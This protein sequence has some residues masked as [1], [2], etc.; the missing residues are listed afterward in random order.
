M[1]EPVVTLPPAAPRKGAP[2]PAPQAPPPGPTQRL[3]DAKTGEAVDLDP[4]AARAALASGAAGFAPQQEVVLTGPGG[5]RKVSGDEARRE[6]LY[7]R[8][9]GLGSEGEWA[10]AE[11]ERREA[12]EYGGVKGAVEAA[13]AG[14]LRGLTF[15]ASDWAARQL[16]AGDTFAKL[17]K[18][19]EGASIAGELAGAALPVVLSGGA[20]APEEAALIAARGG[21]TAAREGGILARGL[22]AYG[23]AQEGIAAAGEAAGRFVP[24][25][26]GAAEGG[27]I[28]KVAGG[29]GR[30]VAE[31]AL[32]GV[33]QAVSD[34]SLKGDPITVDK[35]LAGGGMGALLG[36]GLGGGLAG[37]GVVTEGGLRGVGRAAD[38]AMKE[39]GAVARLLG[40]EVRPMLDELATR[41]AL[42]SVGPTQKMVED[43]RA[44]GPEV[45]KRVAARLL[46]EVPE[47]AGKSSLA[48]MKRQEIAALVE[49]ER[50]A[51]GKAIGA[52]YK[53][54][55]DLLKRTGAEVP[56]VGDA[57]TKVWREVIE[58]LA[59]RP[60]YEGAARSLARSLRTFENS[61]AKNGWSFEAVHRLSADLGATSRKLGRSNPVVGEAYGAAY[62]AMREELERAGDAAAKAAGAAAFSAKI[63]PLNAKYADYVWLSNASKRGVAADVKNRTFGLSEALGAIRGQSVGSS[64]GG[65][66]G[67]LAGPAGQAAGA[68]LGGVAGGFA[69]AVV[70]HAIRTY[71]DQA[72]AVL[73][74]RAVQSDVLRAVTLTVDEMV[75][76]RI[77]AAL[78]SGARVAR[79]VGQRGAAVAARPKDERGTVD[80][81][82]KAAVKEN[83]A[84]LASNG[85]TGKAAT[86][87]I[88]GVHPELAA[89][90]DA[91]GVKV[92][93]NVQK[94]VPKAPVSAS[95]VPLGR[96]IR[97]EPSREKKAAFLRYR[98]AAVTPLRTL[99]RLADG[100]LTREHV[101]GLEE[102]HGPLLDEARA[103]LLAA[104]A[105]GKGKDVPYARRV[106]LGLLFGVPTDVMLLPPVMAATRGV[107]DE[108]EAAAGKTAQAGPPGGPATNKTSFDVQGAASEQATTRAERVERGEALCFT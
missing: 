57:M 41:K 69:N 101:E 83:A 27:A 24:E 73:A 108:L 80:E 77:K 15:G 60:G 30:G 38:W 96:P 25:M 5:P 43:L 36:G 47:L 19:N 16:G 1:A 61:A 53:G 17:Q 33:G 51:T 21:A 13:G 54:L 100:S 95:V 4:E 99:D 64:V 45:E 104:V 50:V 87:R 78:S 39:E 82:Y 81:R 67:S 35:I 18:H 14:A 72:A 85:G 90:L 107:Y 70:Q 11:A 92:A 49:A 28:A 71:G 86:D 84:F 40:R 6:L 32:N 52:E 10:A 23:R 76:R 98:E 93:Q 66:L 88:R 34:A 105:D 46:D 79:A 106:R 89:A 29:V 65:A 102:N 20:A 75:D 63:K 37:L 9:V 58:P 91:G 56:Q 8:G 48:A 3:Y 22:G 68:L 74:K 62:R 2:A 94:R 12:E 103:K 26:L 31:G 55:D 97:V 42:S 44:L 7:G 59:Q